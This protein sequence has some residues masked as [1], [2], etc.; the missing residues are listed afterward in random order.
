MLIGERADP[1]LSDAIVRT[2]AGIAGVC[3]AN[4]IV[5]VQL[6]PNNVVA[7]LSLDFFEFAQLIVGDADRR[8]RRQLPADVGLHVGDVGEDQ[9][10]VGAELASQQ[11]GQFARRKLMQ[12]VRALLAND[13]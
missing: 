7:M 9:Q 5:T 6:A 1:A 2:A 11:R 3:S 12:R 10:R 13:A 8:P 4:G